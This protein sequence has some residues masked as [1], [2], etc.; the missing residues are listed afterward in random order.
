[1]A[2]ISVL[3]ALGGD[4]VRLA[5]RYERTAVL[6]GEYWRLLTGHW[7]HATTAHL[8][9]N[10]AG[11]GLVALLLARDYSL[12]QWLVILGASMAAIDAG[13]VFFQPQL[14]W[15]VGLSGVLHGALAA[16]A[17]T[18]WRHERWPLALALS[19]I[20]G[21]KLAWE[22]WHGALPLAGDLPVIVAAHLYGALGGLAAG[23]ALLWAQNH[24]GH[25]DVPPP[26]Q[27]AGE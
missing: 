20:L 27:M 18:W 6:A 17:V 25:R 22:H 21:G 8:L 19:V 15:Y 23:L 16:G 24:E 2:G 26:P 7:V 3:L 5:L 12:R 10:M 1:M 4:P 14:Q 9:L 11:L 13:F